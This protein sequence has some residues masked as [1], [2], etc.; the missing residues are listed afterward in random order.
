VIALAGTGAE[1]PLLTRPQAG[2]AHQSGHAVFAAMMSLTP[3]SHLQ[4]GAAISFT[5]GRKFLAE[6]Q[7]ELL[8]LLAAEP[9]QLVVVGVITGAGNVQRLTDQLDGFGGLHG[10]RLNQFESPSR[11]GCSEQMAKAFFRISR[12]RWV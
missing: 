8:I 6:D 5:A 2:L 3:Q 1:A 11:P 7:Q 12:C 10:H 9:F 4:S